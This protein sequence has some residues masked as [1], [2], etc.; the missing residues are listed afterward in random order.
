[1]G[2]VKQSRTYL[3]LLRTWENIVSQAQAK[4]RIMIKILLHFSF[5]N[6]IA[7]VNLVT[8]TSIGSYDVIHASDIQVVRLKLQCMLDQLPLLSR[9]VHLRRQTCEANP[10][11]VILHLVPPPK[12]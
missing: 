11:T 3:E 7:M 4:D 8:D 9:E 10:S 6:S 5:W 2:E 1:M 12:G